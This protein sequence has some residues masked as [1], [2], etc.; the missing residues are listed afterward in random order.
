[1]T[2]FPLLLT[3]QASEAFALSFSNSDFISNPAFSNVTP[4]TVPE[5]GTSLLALS[6]LMFF[7]SLRRRSVRN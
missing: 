5:P 1:M 2:G 7:R 6:S 3:K 4:L